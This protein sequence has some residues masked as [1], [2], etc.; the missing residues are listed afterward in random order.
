MPRESAAAATHSLLGR[1]A[2][3]P[4]RLVSHVGAECDGVVVDCIQERRE[5][6]QADGRPLGAHRIDHRARHLCQQA[7]GGQGG[8]MALLNQHNKKNTDW[9]RAN[10]CINYSNSTAESVMHVAWSSRCSPTC[11]ETTLNK[12]RAAAAKPK[13]QHDLTA[14]P[15]GPVLR[16]M[17]AMRTSSAKRARFSSGPPYSSLRWLLLL[18]R[19]WSMMYLR[20]VAPCTQTYP[21]RSRTVHS[22]WQLLAKPQQRGR[23]YRRPST[24]QCGPQVCAL[25]RSLH[26]SPHRQSLQ[27]MDNGLESWGMDGSRWRSLAMGLKTEVRTRGASIPT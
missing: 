17:A 9:A 21:N 15:A 10:V 19:N 3:E 5:G 6:R 1:A 18:F 16:V 4:A 25:T 8:R 26:G 12:R 13:A 7:A 27:Q 20:T 23:T 24:R 22:T 2:S 11:C 14:A